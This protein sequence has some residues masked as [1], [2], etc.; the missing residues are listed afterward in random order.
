MLLR[1]ARSHTRTRHETHIDP[2]EAPC[3]A[4]PLLTLLA[5]AR[6]DL[7]LWVLVGVLAHGRAEGLSPHDW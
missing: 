2:E 3:W 4:V 1:R 6:H 5:M 7:C